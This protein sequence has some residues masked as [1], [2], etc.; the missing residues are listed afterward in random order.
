MMS[1]HQLKSQKSHQPLDREY[2]HPSQSNLLP[3]KNEDY[4][5]Y[6]LECQNLAKSLSQ[7]KRQN[8]ELKAELAA[9][10]EKVEQ[11]TMDMKMLLESKEM[12][13]E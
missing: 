4:Y 10:K 2:S 6:K 9:E 11:V 3:Q 13:Q 1:N 7:E 5:I 12:L 8:E